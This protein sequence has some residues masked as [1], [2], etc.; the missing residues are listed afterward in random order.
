MNVPQWA[1]NL[2]I[3]IR[4]HQN[5]GVYAKFKLY[6]TSA[7]W[8]KPNI[9]R[10]RMAVKWSVVGLCLEFIFLPKLKKRGCSKL[11]TTP[12]R[13]PESLTTYCSTEPVIP[14]K[15]RLTGTWNRA[16]S[17][18]LRAIGEDVKCAFSLPPI[19][20]LS[21]EREELGTWSG[22]ATY[23]TCPAS[24][25]SE[26]QTPVRA[27]DGPADAEL[28]FSGPNR[29]SLVTLDILRR[30]TTFSWQDCNSEKTCCLQPP[31]NTDRWS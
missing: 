31:P 24:K 27:T 19:A 8:N 16:P 4:G 13:M 3:T 11:T 17:D 30:T 25:I 10:K 21:K 29:R 22:T 7:N 15:A 9:Y 26:I 1:I 28:A 6:T 18:Y 5:T 20:W 2:L 12:R 23:S 14:C